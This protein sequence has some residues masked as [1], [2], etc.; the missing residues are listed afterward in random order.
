MGLLP[1]DLGRH[2]GM[3]RDQ[4]T[5]NL[6]RLAQGARSSMAGGDLGRFA[7]LSRAQRQSYL[8]GLARQARSP[9]PLLYDRT[10]ADSMYAGKMAD[11]LRARGGTSRWHTASVKALEQQQRAAAAVMQRMRRR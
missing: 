1:G 2:A 6:A 11:K 8:D 9:G 4:R 7:G 3:T 5:R 10:R